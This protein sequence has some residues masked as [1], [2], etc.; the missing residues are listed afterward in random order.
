MT[1]PLGLDVLARL[2]A[3]IDARRSADTDTSYT[4]KLLGSGTEKC[5]KKFGEEAFELALA[6][7]SGDDVHT[8]AEAADV[9]YHLL[10]VLASCDVPLSQ[11]MAE[12]ERRTAVSGI[13]EKAA[14]KGGKLS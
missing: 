5:A 8:T 14:R 13:E 2:V 12:L 1:D 6:A 4:A 10:V 9:M 11:V 3:T 7:V